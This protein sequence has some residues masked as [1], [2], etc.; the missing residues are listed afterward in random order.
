MLKQCPKCRRSY[1]DQELNYCLDDGALLEWD[2]E[3][4]KTLYMSTVAMGQ[5]DSPGR[6]AAHNV[7]KY[8]IGIGVSVGVVVMAIGFWIIFGLRSSSQNNAAI[9]PPPAQPPAN[10]QA[11]EW[12][13]LMDFASG[14]HRVDY[15]IRG[16]TLRL[17][18]SNKWSSRVR[19]KSKLNAETLVDNE[20]KPFHGPESTVTVN[21]A[22]TQMDNYPVPPGIQDIRNL[23]L[24]IVDWEYIY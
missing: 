21:A 6:S 24:E 8:R 15:S 13:F 23:E 14:E 7:W 20:W 18:F 10:A 1:D 12:I 17:R 5:A 9:L 19:I 3:T 22:S 16:N 2:L 11:D 4:Q